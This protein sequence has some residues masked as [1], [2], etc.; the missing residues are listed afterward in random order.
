MLRPPEKG[1]DSQ[2]EGKSRRTKRE[3]SWEGAEPGWERGGGG[4]RERKWGGGEQEK[5]EEERAEPRWPPWGWAVRE[6]GRL[7]EGIVWKPGA[8]L[9]QARVVCSYPTLKITLTGSEGPAVLVAVR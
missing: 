2:E 9:V 4:R 5:E 8:V 6:L 7:R 3:R 1:G